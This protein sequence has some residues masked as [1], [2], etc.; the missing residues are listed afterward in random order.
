MDA[1]DLEELV[2]DEDLQ[3]QYDEQYDEALNEDDGGAANG[4]GGED[5]QQEQAYED[6]QP[7][8]GARNA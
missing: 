8:G 7:E 4:G 2:Y 6:G 3:G 1:E 5:E